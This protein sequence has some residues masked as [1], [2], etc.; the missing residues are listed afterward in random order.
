M[1][2]FV[3]LIFFNVHFNFLTILY[4]KSDMSDM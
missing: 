4:A 3:L 2:E 1:E